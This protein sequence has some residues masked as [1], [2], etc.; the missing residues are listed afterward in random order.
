MVNVQ[1][2]FN[3]SDEIIILNLEW[4]SGDLVCAAWLSGDLVCAAW[5]SGDLV[6]AA[7]LWESVF[8]HDKL[9]AQKHPPSRTGDKS[10]KGSRWLPMWWSNKKNSCL[11]NVLTLCNAFVN[12]TTAYVRDPQ[13]FAGKR[14]NNNSIFHGSKKAYIKWQIYRKQSYVENNKIIV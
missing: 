6:C 9:F 13:C 12:I 5:L 8:S 10:F 14:C 3:F 2:R 1:P 7:W 11:R 4:L